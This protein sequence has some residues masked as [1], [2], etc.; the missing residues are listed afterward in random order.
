MLEKIAKLDT[1]IL[2][3]LNNL[4]NESWDPF[5]LLYTEKTTH[6]PLMLVLVFF[7]FKTLGA[8]RFFLSLFIIS[9]M[10]V[11]TDQLT[12]LAKYGFERARPCR[13]PE[14]ENLIRYIAKRCSRFGFFSGHS[15]NSMAIAVFTGLILKNKYKYSFPALILWALSMGYSR[16]YV[17]VHYPGDLLVGFTIGALV[18]YSFFIVYTKITHKYIG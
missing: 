2:V 18:A 5:W 14:L 9:L 6:L 1:N 17:G 10:I 13:V 12:N 3:Y 7:L 8:K 11:C 15:S 16:I 4:G